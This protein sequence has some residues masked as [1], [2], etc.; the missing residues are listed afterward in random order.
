MN[1]KTVYE[2][3]FAFQVKSEKDNKPVMKTY[4]KNIIA[5]NVDIAVD[6]V[7]IIFLNNLVIYIFE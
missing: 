1:I 4:T 7:K 3:R 2:I 6:W 5:K